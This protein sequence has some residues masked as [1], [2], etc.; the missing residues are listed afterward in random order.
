[1]TKTAI[2][3]TRESQSLAAG[4]DLGEQIN[5]QLGEARAD[6]VVV[7]ASACFDYAVLLEALEASCRPGVIIGSSS[8]GEFAG[9]DRG[10]GTACAM[11]ISSTDLK[12]AAA[13]GQGVGQDRAQAASQLVGGFQGLTQHEFPFRAAL[14]MADA[15][16][17]HIDELVE[18]LTL[19]TSAH[20]QFAGGGAGDDA[21]FSQTHVFCGTRAYTDSVVALEILSRKPID[22]GVSHG[23]Q[24]A[25]MPYRVTEARGT[26]LISL[27]GLPA[28]EAFEAHA[29]ES[30]QHFDPRA[31]L[32]FFLHNILGIATADGDRLRVPLSIEADG[33]INFAAEVPPGARVYIMKTTNQSAVNAAALA[34]RSA[35]EAIGTETP[36]AA[37]F[38]D[39]VATRLRLGDVFGFELDTVAQ[40]LETTNIV[41]CNTYGQ[42]ARGAGQF[43]GFHNCTAVVLVLPS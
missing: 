8:A 22:V 43:N 27:N 30:G 42:I 3:Y 20:Y 5:A 1:M 38:F 13:L 18:E 11:A 17:G 19:Q 10:E 29:E 14:V 37:F 39:C 2:V 35:L 21:C 9:T 34:T 24:P 15:L 40:V 25:T 26:R 6:A 41:G 32:P 31:P 16:A 23:W 7:F 4:R 12:F 36:G 33:S 28:I